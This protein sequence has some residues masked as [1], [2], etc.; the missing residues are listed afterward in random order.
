MTTKHTRITVADAAKGEALPE[1]LIQLQDLPPVE[2]ARILANAQNQRATEGAWSMA[3]RRWQEGTVYLRKS[4]K[5]PNAWWGRFVETIETEAGTIR[6]QRNVRLGDAKQYTKPL[7]RRALREHVDRANNYQPLTVKSQAM[8]KAAI[9]FSVF[10]A[11]W[12][13]EVLIHKKASTIANMKGHINNLLIPAFGKLAVGDIDSERVQSFLNRF[14]GKLSPKTI[15]NIWITLRVMWN[16]AVAWRYGTGELRVELPKARRLRMRCYTVQEVKRI[17]ANTTGAEQVLFWLLAETGMRIG[18]LI[19]L[20]VSDVDL[21]NLSVE[22][23]KAIWCK[24]EDSPKSEAGMR[25][26]CI[27]GLLGAT[28]KEY[29]AGRTD[30]YLFQTSNGGPWDASN[31]LERK[32]NRLL[33][34]LEIPKIDPKHLSKIVGKGRTI[35]QASRS[36]KR[37]ASVGMHSFRHTNA[38]AMDSLGLPQQIRKQRVG[39]S[40]NSVTENYT[41]TFTQDEREAAEK[42]GQFFGT[43]WPE[44]EQGKVISFPNLSQKEEGLPAS[45]QE[46]LVNQ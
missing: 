35:E 25:T 15:K 36:E 27:S 46:A 31:L 2:P 24:T 32:L 4:K 38:T 44:K 6:K 29:L 18:E 28:I 40:G 41:H 43:G 19:A 20:R 11:R 5:L 12:Q 30:G 8:G 26:V 39:H 17:L 37:A 45:G 16:S 42:L 22:I 7:A 33:E 23:S 10:A 34:R 3:R 21:E 14:V 9:P 1:G 13:E